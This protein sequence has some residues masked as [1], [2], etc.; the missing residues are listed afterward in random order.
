MKHIQVLPAMPSTQS[1]CVG[2]DWLRSDSSVNA[3]A[4]PGIGLGLGVGVTREQQ[5]PDTWTL[6]RQRWTDKELFLVTLTH[7]VKVGGA[8]LPG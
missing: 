3:T 8:A 4:P 7:Q 2:S 5:L 6:L 1:Q